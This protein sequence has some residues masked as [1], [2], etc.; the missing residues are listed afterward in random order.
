[1]LAPPVWPSKLNT[2]L[3]PPRF[4][5]LPL[6][7]LSS[8]LRRHADATLCWAIIKQQTITTSTTTGPHS[9]FPIR[10][11]LYRSSIYFFCSSRFGQAMG[12]SLFACL[13]SFISSLFM[14][15]IP[16]PRTPESLHE[17]GLRSSQLGKGTQHTAHAY[18]LRC[19]SPSVISTPRARVLV[20]SCTSLFSISS[21]E[22]KEQ[23]IWGPL[24]GF[25]T[26]ASYFF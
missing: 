23:R 21:L 19:N 13:F 14:Y 2:V 3:P 26:Y 20:W 22:A 4:L 24:A 16:H 10:S 5:H 15:L 7:L 11:G 25:P 17:V 18:L 8:C 6:P 12:G 1:M 9:L